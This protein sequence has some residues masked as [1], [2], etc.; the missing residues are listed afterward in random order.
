MASTPVI[1]CAKHAR[2]KDS[3]SFFSRTAG[4]RG[5]ASRPRAAG[6]CASETQHL[7]LPPPA[8]GV[9]EQAGR[10]IDR[11]ERVKL[12]HE[13]KAESSLLTNGRFLRQLI[14]PLERGCLHAVSNAIIIP[15][16]PGRNIMPRSN[17]A[18]SIRFES[19]RIRHR[20]I[21]RHCSVTVDH[22]G[23]FST[24]RHELSSSHIVGRASACRAC[25]D[26]V[27]DV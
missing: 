2:A 11:I 5:P 13:I 8:R 15:A 17:N 6:R 21:Q 9:P 16:V 20:G 10:R 3:H 1:A 24:M 14:I 18:H 12:P 4:K 22:S 7:T 19:T 26:H 27:V 23:L 25:E